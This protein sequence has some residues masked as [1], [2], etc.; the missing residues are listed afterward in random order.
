MDMEVANSTICLNSG[1]L[2]RFMVH[3]DSGAESVKTG[4]NGSLKV[5]V[6]CFGILERRQKT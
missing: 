4:K 1:Q 6:S 2:L 5:V 3:C